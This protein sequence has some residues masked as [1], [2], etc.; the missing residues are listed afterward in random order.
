MKKIAILGTGIV[1]NTIGTK[2][3]RLGY[4]VMMGS[5]TN[6]N[7]KAT[8]WVE[9]SGQNASQ[10]AFS[11]AAI[12]GDIILNCVKGEVSLDVLRS[13]GAENLSG[14]ILIDISNPL[15]F[16]R[17]MPPTLLPGLVNTY[18]LGEA[19]QDLL[20]ATRVVKTLNIVNCEVMVDAS[21]YGDLTMFVAGNDA[22][23]KQEVGALLQQFGWNDILDLGDIRNARSTEMMLPVWLSIFIAGQNG[24]FG[25]KVVR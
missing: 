2:L 10:G 18:S 15:D 12:F 25:F 3:V 8:A 24:H 13:A 11:D 4:T 19:I 22:A 14:K 20:P 7:S 21:K 16:S 23:A 17:G 5:R 6:N 9:A 1:G